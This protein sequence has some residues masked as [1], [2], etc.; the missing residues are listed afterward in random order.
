M[1]R[2][3]LVDDEPLAVKRLLRLLVAT[4][5]VEVAGTSTDPTEAIA[6]LNRKTC[7]VLFVDIEM[8]G[9]NGFEMLAQLDHQPFV[10][11]VTAYSEH[12]LRA[13]E[14]NSIDYLVKPVETAKLDR[15][16]NKLEGRLARSEIPDVRSVAEQVLSAI[17]RRYP[18]R[19][20]S[21]SGG[22]VAFVEL[23]RVS[24]F[25]SKDKLTFA[26]TDGHDFVVDH[27]LDQLAQK[28]DPERFVRV[29]RSSLVNLDFMGEAHTWFTGG[30]LLRL[31]DARKSEIAVSRDRVRELKQRLS[32]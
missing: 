15:A 7:D 21:R 8:P 26:A 14:V 28:L 3:F 23:S 2:A 29:H 13:F 20:A 1:I 6:K 25:Y 31:K 17:R 10:V 27:T 11:F 19:I 22:K 18:E 5:R 4:G 32:L 9:M 24:H 16:L 12:A 30:M